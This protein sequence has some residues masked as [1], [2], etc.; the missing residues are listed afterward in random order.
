MKKTPI[1]EW[2]EIG[3][4]TKS[5]NSDIHKLIML[6]S[7]AVGTTKA[8]SLKRSQRHL[9]KFRSDA[10]DRMFSEGQGD[11]NIFYGSD[12]DA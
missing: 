11:T 10:E 6:S 12:S 2:K 5:I 1:E 3:K 9:N 7:K 8:A 4:L